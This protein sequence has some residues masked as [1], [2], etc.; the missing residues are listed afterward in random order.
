MVWRSWTMDFVG[1]GNGVPINRD[2]L[3][4]TRPG[5]RQ[6]TQVPAGVLGDLILEVVH[7]PV[8]DFRGDIERGFH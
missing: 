2:A 6:L 8:F 3:T 7:D 1:N 5:E 4:K